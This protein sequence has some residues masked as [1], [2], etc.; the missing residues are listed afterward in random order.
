[1]GSAMPAPLLSESDDASGDALFLWRSLFDSFV[2]ILGE[3]MCRDR[4][5]CGGELVRVYLS[6]KA[7]LHV[8]RIAREVKQQLAEGVDIAP[9]DTV[10]KS[11]LQSAFEEAEAG[12]AEAADQSKAE[13]RE[14]W[15]TFTEARKIY[16]G[17]REQVLEGVLIGED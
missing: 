5:Y 6:P 14:N 3:A 11:A 15:E 2:D 12:A 1:M 10:V 8:Q 4:F 16:R 7:R 9:S 17:A 13:D